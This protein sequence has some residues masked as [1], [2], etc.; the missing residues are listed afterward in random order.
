MIKIINKK[1]AL[2]RKIY[3]RKLFKHYLSK[4]HLN[5]T[6]L[7]IIDKD[8][9]SKGYS[10]V[11]HDNF[12]RGHTIR[13]DLPSIY[14][15]RVKNG[16]G[17]SYYNNR[18]ERLFFIRNNKKLALRFVILHELGHCIL[19]ERGDFDK[20]NREYNSDSYAIEQL[21]KEGLLK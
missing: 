15:D 1:R 11:I 13:I 16:Y 10:G 4:E 6:T 12:T 18:D 7:R 21:Q 5:K 19:K 8:D 3:I 20:K 14:K 17:I 9:L 2:K